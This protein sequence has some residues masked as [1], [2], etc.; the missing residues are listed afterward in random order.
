MVY[1]QF[2]AIVGIV[3]IS[4]NSSYI[5]IFENTDFGHVTEVSNQIKFLQMKTCII[6]NS[7]CLYREKS[8]Q[9]LKRNLCNIYYESS[10]LY[11]S[12]V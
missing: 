4:G 1:Q 7:C 9:Y 3:G 6:C 2:A 5:K 11:L 12:N 8:I 10:D